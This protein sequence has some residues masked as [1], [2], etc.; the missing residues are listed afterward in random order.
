M[1]NYLGIA[2]KKTESTMVCVNHLWLMGP[3][4]LHFTTKKTRKKANLNN[5][6]QPGNYKHGVTTNKIRKKVN[7][8]N[9]IKPGS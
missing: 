1:V 2:I 7:S 3:Y 8:N 6:I 9:G 4:Y 5:G